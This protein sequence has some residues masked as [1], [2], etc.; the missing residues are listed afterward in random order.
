[1]RACLAAITVLIAGILAAAPL[2]AAPP[3][4]RADPRVAARALA[5]HGYALYEA[6]KY[7]EAIDV[8]READKLYHAPTLVFALARAHAGAGQLVEA[9][10][11]LQRVIDEPV[12]TGAPQAFRDAQR[13]AREE[14][15]GLDKRIPTLQI[16]VRGGAGHGLRV[17][18]DDVEIPAD[19]Q[20][21]PLPMNPGAHRVTVVP[22]GGVGTSKTVDLKEGAQLAVELEL[23]FAAPAAIALPPPLPPPA[24]PQRGSLVPALVGFGVG[25]VGLGLGIGAGVSADKS[26]ADLRSKCGGNVCQPSATTAALQSELSSARGMATA[27]TI[28]FVLAGVGAAAGVV[29]LVVRPRSKAAQVG[30]TLGPASLGVA[31]V[32]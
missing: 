16:A 11:L 17:M 30:I 1:M 5:E 8:L 20:D 4:D 18:V 14:L 15:V 25:A 9:R 13:L 23:P 27:S 12:P 31:G 28:G 29:L 10:A 2:H 32:L 21:R 24:Q 3:D 19:R 7:R 26:A 6:G 22:L